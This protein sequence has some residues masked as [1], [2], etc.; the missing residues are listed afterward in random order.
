MSDDITIRPLVPEEA[1]TYQ[2]LRLHALQEHPEAFGSSYEEEARLTLAEVASR[3]PD[4]KQ[5]DVILG[6]YTVENLVG[7]V[8]IARQRL[9]KS[10]HR[11]FVWGMYVSPDWRGQHIGRRLIEAVLARAR[12]M[13][14]LELVTLAVTIGN[15]AARSLYE[16]VGFKPYCLDED[17]L[18]VDG[19]PYSLESMRLPLSV[20]A[21]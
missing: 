16:S 6:A 17:Y 10:R 12:S 3:I 21:G 4:G 5:G 2:A 18:R 11:S 8:G 1:E 7:M 15:D 19:K 20:D 14:G 13:E 9:L